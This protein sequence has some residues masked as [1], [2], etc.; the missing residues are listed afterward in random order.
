MIG[1]MDS[2][3]HTKCIISQILEL[4]EFVES[5]I[6]TVIIFPAGFASQGDLNKGVFTQAMWGWQFRR[7]M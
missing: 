1:L 4:V 6:A 7:A 2:N 5:I 3:T